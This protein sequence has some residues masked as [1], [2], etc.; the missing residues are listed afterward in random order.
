MGAVTN[1]GLKTA[2]DLGA[3]VA[4]TGQTV[5]LRHSGRDV[6]GPVHGPPAGRSIG[7]AP[8][9][10]VL[11]GLLIAGCAEEPCPGNPVLAAGTC[12][13][14]NSPSAQNR[15]L[16]GFTSFQ[17]NATQAASSVASLMGSK[18]VD[19]LDSDAG[20]SKFKADTGATIEVHGDTQRPPT[21]RDVTWF[22]ASIHASPQAAADFVAKSLGARLN[23]TDWPVVAKPEGAGGALLVQKA[24]PPDEW[25]EYTMATFY[26]SPSLLVVFRPPIVSNPQLISVQNATRSAARFIL[27]ANDPSHGAPSPT[28]IEAMAATRTTAI[29]GINHDPAVSYEI[30]FDVCGLGRNGIHVDAVTG[31]IVAW[32]DARWRASET[33]SR[34]AP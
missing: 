15:I 3:S 2:V 29:F 27:C 9:A 14:N 20:G 17:G 10:M 28:E 21:I 31:V 33:A 16:D 26:G 30:S 23:A 12:G 25:V 11:V 32:G 24:P 8:T 13:Y 4:Q 1:P 18:V 34:I 6:S 22:G 5:R 19:H 7:M